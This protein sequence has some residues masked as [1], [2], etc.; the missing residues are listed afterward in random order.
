MVGGVRINPEPP[1]GKPDLTPKAENMWA[2]A[3]AAYKRDGN[4]D[5]IL[6]RANLSEENKKLIIEQANQML[7]GD[8]DE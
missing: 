6:K 3:I 5:A 2:N 1:R 8:T 7:S 4:F